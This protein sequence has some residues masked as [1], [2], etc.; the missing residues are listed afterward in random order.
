MAI[1]AARPM[2][3]TRSSC[4]RL[5]AAIGPLRVAAIGLRV[6]PQPAGLPGLALDRPAVRYCVL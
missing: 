5:R 1:V 2:R 4:A 3:T 6:R